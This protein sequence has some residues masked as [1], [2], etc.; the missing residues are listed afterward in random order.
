M[1]KWCIGF[2]AILVGIIVCGI[3]GLIVGAYIGGNYAQDFTLIG[4]R[5]Y[6]AVGLLGLISGS[7]AGGVLGLVLTFSVANRNIPRNMD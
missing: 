7:I 1:R 3:L 5:G 4:R 6:E 2:L